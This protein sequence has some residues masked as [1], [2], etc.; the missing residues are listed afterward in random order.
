MQEDQIFTYILLHFLLDLQLFHVGV[1]QNHLGFYLVGPRSGPKDHFYDG[2]YDVGVDCK[3]KTHHQNAVDGLD[4]VVGGDVSVADRRYRAYSP[5]NDVEV[6][7]A[8][9]E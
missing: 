1:D 7:L 3:A 8:P 9:W 5:V 2:V 4:G 6:L